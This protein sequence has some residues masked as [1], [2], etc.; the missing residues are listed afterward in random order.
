MDQIPRVF[1]VS[2]V[3]HLSLEDRETLQLLTS[4]TEFHKV[5]SLFEENSN[6]LRIAISENHFV[7]EESEF[8]AVDALQEYLDVVELHFDIPSY[9]EDEESEDEE[10][11]D[12]QAVREARKGMIKFDFAKNETRFVK[13]SRSVPVVKLEL[14]QEIAEESEKFSEKME[15]FLSHQIPLHAISITV[16]QLVDDSILIESVANVFAANVETLDRVN[17]EREEDSEWNEKFLE[18]LG[19]A[20][21]RSPK[22]KLEV[23]SDSEE[24]EVDLERRLLKKWLQNDVSFEE[25]QA[26]GSGTSRNAHPLVLA[27][28][29]FERTE[30]LKFGHN[31]SNDGSKFLEEIGELKLGRTAKNS[32]RRDNF[33]A[34]SFLRV[35]T[36]PH[37][38]IPNNFACVVANLDW[39][40]QAD[41]GNSHLSQEEF[42]ADMGNGQ[43]C[44]E[45]AA[46]A[47]SM[48]DDQFLKCC[49]FSLYFI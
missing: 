9:F 23:F 37:P 30:D 38:R 42:E 3:R 47:L 19:T 27:D 24:G 35:Y 22:M 49:F 12:D 14:S 2:T 39:D 5:A 7:V 16:N 26:M 6:E 43:R 25:K 21:L 15:R 1:V 44:K 11:D 29:G 4:K 18:T 28:F 17:I 20:F 8:K 13:L 32:L 10:E 40:T 33:E 46:N 45:M 41:I 36:L 31:G 34:E 48:T